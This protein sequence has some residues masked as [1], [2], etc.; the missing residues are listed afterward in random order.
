M[1]SPFNEEHP[2]ILYCLPSLIINFSFSRPSLEMIVGI[3]ES[4]RKHILQ[5]TQVFV[6]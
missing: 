6:N 4:V 5:M 3:I 2:V 1:H